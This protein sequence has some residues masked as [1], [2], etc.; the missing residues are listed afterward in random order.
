MSKL[1]LNIELEIPEEWNFTQD[2]ISD[3]EMTD[4]QVWLNVVALLTEKEQV[5]INN[6]DKHSVTINLES[7][8]TL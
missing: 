7:Y 8:E 5:E 6:Y 3:S 4:A 1:K 2:D